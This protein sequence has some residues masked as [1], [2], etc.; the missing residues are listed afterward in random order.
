MRLLHTHGW[1]DQT[2]PLEGRPLQP[3]LE[4]GDIFAGL[5]IWRRENGCTGLQADGFATDA[6]CW[7]RGWDRCAPTPA[8]ELALHPGGHEVPGEWADMALDWF[9]QVISRIACGGA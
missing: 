7:R 6:G 3:G 1:R 2:V 9:E 4:Q 8:L 5:E